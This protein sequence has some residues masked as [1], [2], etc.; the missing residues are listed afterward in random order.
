M[1][2][3]E[4]GKKIQAC[5]ELFKHLTKAMQRRGILVGSSPDYPRA[6]ISSVNEQDTLDKGGSVR[7]IIVTIDSMSAKSLGEAMDIS[8]S[9]LDK[10]KLANSEMEHFA[11][12]GV[13]EST[14]NTMEE[15]SD[16]KAVL[17]RVIN[18]LTFYL[19]EK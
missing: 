17:Y 3:I 15:M 12:I 5:D 7:R 9:N 6:E 13:T 11:I 10:I 2:M 8:Q 1:T 14:A 16:T 19:S 4:I 18:N